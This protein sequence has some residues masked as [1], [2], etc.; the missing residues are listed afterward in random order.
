MRGALG[1]LA[2]L[3]TGLGWLVF[4]ALLGFALYI[5]LVRS[6]SL[7]ASLR[8]I[9]VHAG[10]I[11]GLLQMLIGA[12]L[13]WLPTTLPSGRQRPAS[14]PGLYVLLNVG[15]LGML[16]GFWLSHRTTVGIAGVVTVIPVLA[17]LSD[18]LRLAK[19]QQGWLL[20]PSLYYGASL[21]GL[22]FGIGAGAAICFG[23]IPT[24]FVAQV[25]FAHVQL[26]LSLFAVLT[27]IGLTLHL[28][29]VPMKPGA[30]GRVSR[31]CPA[32]FVVGT[33]LLLTGFGVAMVPLQLAGGGVLL[34]G[35]LIYVWSMVEL[36]KTDTGPHR[37][38]S[39]QLALGSCFLSLAILGGLLASTNSLGEQPLF[40]FGT[41]HVV[42]YTHLAFIGFF[43]QTLFAGLMHL[44]PNM[45]ALRRLSS[46]KKRGA[47]V[48]SFS[49]VTERWHSLQVAALCL[50]TLGLALVASLTWRASLSDALVQQAMWITLGLL[51]IGLTI[52]TAKIV[53]LLGH[54]PSE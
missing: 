41:L 47:Y 16:I 40:P 7:P 42:A 22:L 53:L 28:M 37:V 43:A 15:T 33:A 29:P 31:L 36:W 26:T 4:S 48:A 11:G 20:A 23:L 21:A 45:L 24:A 32:L 2:F 34:V 54:R 25:R 13:Y 8:S 27:L 30:H 9:H 19:D 46:A 50:G 39:D 35:S 17:L 3:L 6:T 5:G 51:L 12:L 38:V 1:P 52:V 14:R 49:P 18:A 10:M 44:L